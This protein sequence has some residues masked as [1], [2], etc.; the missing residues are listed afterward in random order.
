MGGNA[1][2]AKRAFIGRLR[3]RWSVVVTLYT[4]TPT[5]LLILFLSSTFKSDTIALNM[6][7]SERKIL[8]FNSNTV[9]SNRG[10]RKIY[11][12]DKNDGW[13]HK[14]TNTAADGGSKILI[15]GWLFI[16]TYIHTCTHKQWIERRWNIYKDGWKWIA[17]KNIKEPKLVRKYIYY[18][19]NIFEHRFRILFHS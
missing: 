14:L 13:Y 3:T 2:L 5:Y 1:H 12:Y 10:G 8:K 7:K 15:G 6:K 16:C 4:H 9:S 18:I 19:S 11:F 17:F